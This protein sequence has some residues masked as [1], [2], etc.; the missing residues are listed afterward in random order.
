M[1][2][3]LY[4]IYSVYYIFSEL[5]KLQHS[6]NKI[7]KNKLLNLKNQIFSGGCLNIKFAQ[8]Y[9][10][11]IKS[12]NDNN[13]KQIIDFFEDIF[14]QCPRH[15]IK[16]TLQLFEQDF[17]IQLHNI[18]DIN[19]LK[20]IASGS[21][22]QVYK[23]KLFKPIYIVDT[24][25]KD[26]INIMNNNSISIN[27]VL[28]DY[29]LDYSNI[30]DI[31]KSLS[32][33][34][35]WIALKVKHPGI[36]EDIEYKVSCVD[37]LTN[38]Q[39]NYYI[40]SYLG[41]HVDFKDFINNL[42]QQIDFHNEYYNSF[43]FRKNFAG[44]Y[45]T[46]FPRVLWCS[47]NILITEF[48]ESKDINEMSSFNQL[49][50]CTNFA[51]AISQMVLIDNFCH[52]DIHDKNWG[53]ILYTDDTIKN[54]PKLVFYDYG[55]CFKNTDEN[56]NIRIWEEF[57]NCNI[58]GIVEVSKELIIGNYDKDIIKKELENIIVFYKKYSLDI[59]NLIHNINNVLDKY[60]N[61]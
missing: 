3:K 14:E 29:W 36:N 10:S 53:V 1:F 59:I 37:I 61:I 25:H 47:E 39:N 32:K 42:E 40:K 11:K 55:I 26:I 5:D 57:E 24:S 48:A 19:S 52:G 22:G 34:I 23:C 30:P 43:I 33:K 27:D 60:K 35:E 4:H 13:S 7:E 17:K 54:E 18:I 2:G 8:W 9:I 50:T 45:L 38:M 46:Y 20:C 56:I 15:D 6:T 44:N 16:Y 31:L 49:K 41:L 28:C 12:N 21:I 58:E 51:C